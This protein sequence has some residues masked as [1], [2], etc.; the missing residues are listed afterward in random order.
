MQTCQ[1]VIENILANEQGF[2]AERLQTRKSDQELEFVFLY[3]NQSIVLHFRE[4]PGHGAPVHTEKISQ[5]IY[6]ILI[7]LLCFMFSVFIEV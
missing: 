3:K 7:G 1:Q 6:V 5:L 4:F 2:H